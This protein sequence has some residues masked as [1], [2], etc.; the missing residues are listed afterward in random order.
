MVAVVVGGAGALG[1]AIIRALRRQT[2]KQNSSSLSPIPIISVDYRACPCPEATHSVVLSADGEAWDAVGEGVLEELRA[3]VG[4]NGQ[5]ASVFHAAG[6][7]AGGCVLG[8][9][10]GMVACVAPVLQVMGSVTC[11]RV[12]HNTQAGPPGRRGSWGAW[13]RCG[14]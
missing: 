4:G 11:T 3:V 10:E 1:S 7:W 13:I 8:A 5:A 2:S 14:G 9:E 12:V 6:G